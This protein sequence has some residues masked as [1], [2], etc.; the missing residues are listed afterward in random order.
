MKDSD[1]LELEVARIVSGILRVDVGV[2]ASRL[3]VPGWDSLRHVE[4]L[5]AVEEA[6]GVTLDEAEM[7]AL[8]SVKSLAR[9]VSMPR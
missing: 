2:D 9:R 1:A 8:D 7:A 5:F 4:I 6:Y 3:N